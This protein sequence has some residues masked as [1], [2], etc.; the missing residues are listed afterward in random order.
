MEKIL[1]KK[2]AEIEDLSKALDQKALV[3]SN[4]AREEK[5]KELSAKVNDFKSLQKNYT[6]VLRELEIKSV[7]QVRKDVTEIV[8]GI[9]KQGGYSL[10]IDRRAGGVVYAPNAIE[11]TD[12]V[13]ELYN[14]MDAKRAKKEDKSVGSKKE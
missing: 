14:A 11:I 9:G 8:E 12:K 4:D 1:K 13:I 7:N 2:G 3:M 10:I 5:E 6:D